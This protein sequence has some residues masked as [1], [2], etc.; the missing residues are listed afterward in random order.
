ME[1]AGD[2]AFMAT[3]SSGAPYLARNELV[4]G[5]LEGSNVK[6]LEG[7][8]SLIRLERGHQANLKVI[9]AYRDA[10]EQLIEEAGR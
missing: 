2:G 4:I 6:P 3:Q 1:R 5:Y 9:Q 7:M 8:V 10:D